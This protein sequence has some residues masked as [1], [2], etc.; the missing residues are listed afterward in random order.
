MLNYTM[1]VNN[2]QISFKANV[3]KSIKNIT[4]N[5]NPSVIEDIFSKTYGIDAKFDN[6]K[7]LT[8]LD[9]LKLFPHCLKKF[10]EQIIADSFK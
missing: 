1:Q 10:F 9:K 5:V 8:T 4:R 6:D 7:A 2:Y 3:T